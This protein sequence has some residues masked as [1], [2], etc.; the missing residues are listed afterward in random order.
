V[1]FA[2]MPLDI[3][4]F[5]EELESVRESERRRDG[6]NLKPETGKLIDEIVELDTAWRGG[7]H[8]LDNLRKQKNINSKEVKKRKQ[9]KQNCQ[10]LIEASKAITQEVN[11]LNIT[12][13]ANS[14]KLEKKIRQAGNFVH[15]SVPVS[16]DEEDNIVVKSW[17]QCRA[18]S[19]KKLHHHQILHMLDGYESM[20]AV[21]VSGHRAYFLRGVGVLLNQA[22]LN[23]GLFFF[24]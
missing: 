8:E 15:P 21:K 2:T 12:T 19:G 22:L 6:G 11:A 7:I 1:Q 16:N 9:A 3:L 20:R 10:D 4:S 5:R 18:A 23:Y 13:K 24:C 14:Q 17:G